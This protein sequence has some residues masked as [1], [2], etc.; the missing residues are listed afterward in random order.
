MAD[1]VAAELRRNAFV[2]SISHELRSPLHGILAS[3][4]SL[5][6][7]RCDVF[8][9]SL[10]D[11]VDSCGRTLLDTINHVLD[12]SKMSSFGSNALGLGGQ[13]DTQSATLNKFGNASFASM[14]GGPLTV[15]AETNVA[16]ICE[17]VVEGL[18]VGQVFPLQDHLRASTC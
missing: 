3:A 10:V 5:G 13:S 4:D 6:E 15:S 9:K 1:I 2:S 11:T 8:Q 18:V 12:F 14:T 17:E 7:T 16:A